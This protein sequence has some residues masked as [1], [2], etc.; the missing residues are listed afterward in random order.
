MPSSLIDKCQ[1]LEGS[2]ASPSG[3]LWYHVIMIM[4][5]P[6]WATAS[7]R[8]FFWIYIEL[9]HLVLTSVDSTIIIYFTEQGHQPCIQPPNL[10]DQV[11]VFM[12]PSDRLAQLYSEAPGSLFI[13][14]SGSRLQWMYSDLPHTGYHN[15]SWMK[16]WVFTTLFL[17]FMM[18]LFSVILSPWGRIT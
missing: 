14:F 17:Y 7:L 16:N 12:A 8:R 18:V 11:S 3:L 13:S 9:D 10:E 2:S 15:F 4:I 5:G 6:F 1:H